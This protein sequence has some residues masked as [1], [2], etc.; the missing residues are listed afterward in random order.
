M[1]HLSPSIPGAKGVDF[2]LKS[3]S[4]LRP[5]RTSGLLLHK[6]RGVVCA[7]RKAERIA[8]GIGL[9]H[10]MHMTDGSRSERRLTHGDRQTFFR[11]ADSFRCSRSSKDCGGRLAGG[12]TTG[13]PRRRPAQPFQP[14]SLHM[15]SLATDLRMTAA[16]FWRAPSAAASRSPRE[17]NQPAANQEVPRWKQRYAAT[18]TSLRSSTSSP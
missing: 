7:V 6:P 8:P 16:R 18:A 5:C 1:L 3:T 12:R 2:G 9:S 10:P 14:W 15:T 17:S 11:R 13:H 4:A